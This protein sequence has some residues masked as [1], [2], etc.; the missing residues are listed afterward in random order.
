MVHHQTATDWCRALNLLAQSVTAFLWSTSPETTAARSAK[1]DS[2]P[3][4][5]QDFALEQMRDAS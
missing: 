4:L 1:Q 5:Y 3:S 2:D